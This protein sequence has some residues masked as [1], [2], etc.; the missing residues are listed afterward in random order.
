MPLLEKS[1]MTD[2]A[3]PTGLRKWWADRRWKSRRTSRQDG[4]LAAAARAGR[5]TRLRRLLIGRRRPPRLFPG[6]TFGYEYFIER[7]WLAMRRGALWELAL[8]RNLDFP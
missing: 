4:P 6:W 7:R 5:R 8:E 2:A 1:A 3:S